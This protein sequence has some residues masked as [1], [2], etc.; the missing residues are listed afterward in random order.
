MQLHTLIALLNQANLC[1]VDIAPFSESWG[2][3]GVQI[4]GLSLSRGG[5][6]LNLIFQH[7]IKNSI[8]LENISQSGNVLGFM[9]LTHCG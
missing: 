5:Q 3:R 6:L 4:T 9:S 7:F 1:L 8:C 2:R